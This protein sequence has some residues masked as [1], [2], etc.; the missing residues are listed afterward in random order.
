MEVIVDP[1]DESWDQLVPA[2]SD[3]PMDSP[4]GNREAVLPERPKPRH[5]VVEVRVD[6]RSVDVE[7]NR[8]RD[9][10]VVEVG[11]LIPSRPL[12]GST[13]ARK[14]LTRPSHTSNGCGYRTS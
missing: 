8:A 7:Q 2:H 6:Q 3:V 14:V 9:P 1:Q 12:F 10:V 11:H 5:G 13:A 4:Q